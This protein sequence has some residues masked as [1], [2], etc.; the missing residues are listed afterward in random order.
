MAN[1]EDLE[2]A[3]RGVKIWNNWASGLSRTGA[4]H[5]DF[6][7]ASIDFSD[8]SSFLFPGPVSFKGATFTVPITFNSARFADTAHFDGAIFREDAIFDRANFS[9][10]ASFADAKF[11]SVTSFASSKFHRT[12]NFSTVE[13][14]DAFEFQKAAV[15][16]TADFSRARFANVDF[17]N[18]RFDGSLQ[19]PGM[20]V[21]G[22]FVFADTS[23][24]GEASFADAELASNVTFQRASLQTTTFFG[25][26]FGGYTQFNRAT[27][28]GAVDFAY[29]SF[30]RPPDFRATT[31]TIS[32][33]LLGAQVGYEVAIDT[34]WWRKML[35]CAAQSHD[36]VLYRHLKR[37]AGDAKDHESE[38]AFFARELRAKRFHET[39]GFG[40]LFMN[41][42][43][44]VLSRYGQSIARPVIAL[45][46]S[47]LLATAMIASMYWDA[48]IPVLSRLAAAFELGITN[49]TLLVGSERWA[50]RL[51][52]FDVLCPGVAP[53][54]GHVGDILAYLQSAFSLL[55]L[56][57]IG[58]AL[59]NRFRIG[60]GN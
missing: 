5:I 20:K 30:S 15:A 14:R 32:P 2:R 17:A 53:R 56:F 47:V 1:P 45:L 18:T 52:A 21:S 43:Y 25:A 37:L 39:K 42:G 29:S 23:V 10:D 46:S 55:L 48:P 34:T 36:A 3:K 41:I 22:D 9:A 16:T 7:E 19:C 12:V 54:F 8:F 40:P 60:S 28:G 26:K 59:R 27:F 11:L 24:A 51:N 13:S 58:L 33:T 35:F 57:L 31:F 6:S 50:P 44:D 38:L 49:A 4:I